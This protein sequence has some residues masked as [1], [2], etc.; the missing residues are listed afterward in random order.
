[1]E[2]GFKGR[3]CVNT[4]ERIGG[5]SEVRT[6]SVREKLLLKKEWKKENERRDGARTNL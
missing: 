2:S 3:S 6:P 4:V 5:S 1:V